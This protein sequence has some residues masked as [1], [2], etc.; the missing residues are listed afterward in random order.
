MPTW[1]TMEAR[2]DAMNKRPSSS[3]MAHTDFPAFKVLSVS[4]F[5]V[6][7]IDCIELPLASGQAENEAFDPALVVQV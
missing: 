1:P 7:C 3:P 2:C 5:Y 6:D 4:M